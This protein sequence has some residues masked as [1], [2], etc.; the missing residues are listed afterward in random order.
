M[1]LQTLQEQC[2]LGEAADAAGAVLG[3]AAR[4]VLNE[5]AGAVLDEAA[6]AVLDEAGALLGEVQTLWEQCSN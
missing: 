5:A 2:S 3:E 1:R 6:G 4:A